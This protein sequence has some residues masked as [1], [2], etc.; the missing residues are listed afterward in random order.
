MS[1]FVD[2]SVP[3]DGLAPLGDRS[4]AGTEMKTVGHIYM[5]LAFKG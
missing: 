1:S 2:S 4:S 3:V 5:G